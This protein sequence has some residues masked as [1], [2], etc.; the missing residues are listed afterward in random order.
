MRKSRHNYSDIDADDKPFELQESDLLKMEVMCPQDGYSTLPLPW[1]HA[2][3]FPDAHY[4]RFRERMGTRL[5]REPH[6]YFHREDKDYKH[7]IYWRS[8]KAD[9]ALIEAGRLLQRSPRPKEHRGHSLQVSMYEASLKLGA[10]ARKLD[11]GLL[12]IPRAIRLGQRDEKGRELIL[13]PDGRPL[14]VFYPN[15]PINFLKE[16]DNATEPYSTLDDK[17]RRYQLFVERKIWRDLGLNNCMVIVVTVS[18]QK[19]EEYMKRAAAI[20]GKQCKWLLFQT[21]QHHYKTRTLPLPTDIMFTKPY[22]R[23]GLPDFNLIKGE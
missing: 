2:L 6:A 15:N 8:Y 3:A 1:I 16:V 7:A 9:D 10:R 18:E 23:I 5:S 14:C 22:Q 19:K 21:W 11:I 20:V 4:Q 13:E 17:F 12:D